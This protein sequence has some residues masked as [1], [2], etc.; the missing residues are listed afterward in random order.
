MAGK[1]P[2]EGMVVIMTKDDLPHPALQIEDIMTVRKGKVVNNTTA[3]KAAKE[4]AGEDKLTVGRFSS[5]GK[6]RKQ[7]EN[8]PLTGV[9]VGF[10]ML[11]EE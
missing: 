3:Y 10:L 9:L 4:I 8:I 6:W 1:C 2:L 7:T 11:K 5:D